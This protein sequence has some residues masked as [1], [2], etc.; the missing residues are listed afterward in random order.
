MQRKMPDWAERKLLDFRG[1][2]ILIV[3]TKIYSTSMIGDKN[4]SGETQQIGDQ[5]SRGLVPL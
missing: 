5:L 1:N 3:T 4:E 2:R